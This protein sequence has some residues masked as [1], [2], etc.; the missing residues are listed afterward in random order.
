L[1]GILD[2]RI[3][4]RDSK[5]STNQGRVENRTELADLLKPKFKIRSSGELMEKIHDKKIPAGII[6]N[7]KEALKMPGIDSIFLR[8]NQLTGIRNFI[9][10]FSQSPFNSSQ[11]ILPPPHF[12]EHTELILKTLL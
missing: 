7:I 12:G 2:I 6:Q 11:S 8:S 10:S 1:C 3:D 5:F 9:G 4:N